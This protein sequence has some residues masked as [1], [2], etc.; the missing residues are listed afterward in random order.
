VL[1][2]QHQD[3]DLVVELLADIRQIFDAFAA[4][5]LASADLCDALHGIEDHP[6]GE[7]RGLHDNRTPRPLS[8]PEL[9][10]LLR[11]FGIA[12]RPLWPPGPRSG[13]KSRRGYFRHQF[14]SVWAAYVDLQESDEEATGRGGRASL[15]RLL[16]PSQGRNRGVN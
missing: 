7:W 9:S 4:D 16:N 10:N 6:W 1:S 11:P 5:R 2:R 3:E 12:P 14:E 15:L 8:Q 13:L